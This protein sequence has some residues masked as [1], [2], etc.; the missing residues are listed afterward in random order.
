M[1]SP[2]SQALS[3]IA[4]K[5]II[6][7]LLQEV[8]FTLDPPPEHGKRRHSQREA[9]TTKYVERERVSEGDRQVDECG[10]EGRYRRPHCGL[11]GMARGTLRCRPA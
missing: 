10:E 7:E 2:G 1:S 8:P 5:G 3:N 4:S 6:R 11:P 9:T